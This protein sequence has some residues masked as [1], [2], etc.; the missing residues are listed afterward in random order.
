M[1]ANDEEMRAKISR[2]PVCCFFFFT[3]GIP[4][5]RKTHNNALDGVKLRKYPPIKCVAIIL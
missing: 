5:T 2:A 4:D 1:V 3:K